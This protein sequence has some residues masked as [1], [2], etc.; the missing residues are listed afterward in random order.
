MKPAKFDYH[1]AEN[2][3]HA[4]ALLTEY[5]DDAKILAGGQSL[6]AAMNYRLA[7]PEVLIDISNVEQSNRVTDEQNGVRVKATT[8]QRFV[9]KD[10]GLRQRI[11]VLAYAI[12]HIAHF[13]IRNKGT[14]GGSI[15]NADPASELPAMSLLLD[16]EFEIESASD[17]TMVPAEDFFI[18]YMT[19]SLQADEILSSALF[20]APPQTSGWGFRE[21]TRRAGDFALAGSAAIVDLDADSKCSY[22][23]VALFGVAATPVRAREVE[24]ALLEKQCS[25]ELLQEAAENVREIIDPESDVH[26]TEEYRRNVVEVLTIRA[27]EDAFSRAAVD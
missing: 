2:I 18:T 16:A 20:K 27:L 6:I 12:E 26:V 9:E 23:R 7:R 24:Q 5:G 4:C 14:V 11:P 22:A 19:T 17:K 8:T 3:Q 21:V 25:S 13:Q 10:A 15:V 1:R